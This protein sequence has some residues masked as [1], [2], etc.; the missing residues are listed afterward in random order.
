LGIGLAQMAAQL[1]RDQYLS[2]FRSF[3]YEQVSNRLFV[4]QDF[5]F[6]YYA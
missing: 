2:A 4:R 6:C 1:I 5:P 3:Y